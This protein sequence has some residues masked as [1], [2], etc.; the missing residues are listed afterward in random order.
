[1]SS[2]ASCTIFSL[3]LAMNTSPHMTKTAPIEVYIKKKKTKKQKKK[4]VLGR[5]RVKPVT[6]NFAF[7]GDKIKLCYVS[8]Q[9][10]IARA[11]KYKI[12]NR[13]LRDTRVS[14][15]FYPVP[16]PKQNTKTI[17]NE[18]FRNSKTFKTH[19]NREKVTC[20]QLHLI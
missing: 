4:K 19:K 18:K 5:I 17:T 3:S 15:V 9:K 14:R 20:L 11:R 1:M 12:V 2:S 10:D 7:N 13:V 16:N 6:F 8:S